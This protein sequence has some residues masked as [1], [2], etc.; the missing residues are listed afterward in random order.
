MSENTK[1]SLSD[2]QKMENSKNPDLLAEQ[3]NQAADEEKI[4]I[5][6]EFTEQPKK[7]KKAYNIIDGYRTLERHEMPF[8]G[9]FY[10]SSW[11][12]AYR[13]P[14]T[15]EVANFSTIADGDN[16]KIITT[17]TDLIKK[18]FII[19]D[20][21]KQQE[22][23]SA[24]INDG[25]RLFFFLKLREF[26]MYDKPIEY[27]TMS[28]NF[29]EPVTVKFV[30]DSLQFKTPSNKLLECFDG[31]TFSI[32]VPNLSEPIKFL[33]PTLETGSRIFRYVLKS[34]TEAQKDTSDN[35][36]NSEAFN[37]DFLFLAP[38]LYVT[39]EENIESLKL[40]YKQIEKNDDQFKA[41]IQIINSLNITN[42][43]QIKYMYKESEEEALMKFPGGWKHIFI[44]K[45]A[46][47]GLFD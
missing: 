10:P 7:L 11:E 37:K 42:A 47:S 18:C 12:F 30:A 1:P 46:F 22:V 14:T 16:S 26:Y 21:T 28:Q 36:K 2:L 43:E 23:P 25:E 15:K 6:T 9:V 33:I 39:G 38:Y 5:H 41:Y 8:G 35:M 40:K 13:C 32:P 45:N 4:E 17:I 24:Q 20:R 31:R 29:D 44:D 3:L 19:V 27:I 34:Y